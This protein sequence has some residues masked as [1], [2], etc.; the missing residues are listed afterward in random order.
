MKH[1]NKGQSIGSLKIYNLE[2]D[3]K[4]QN[5]TPSEQLPVSEQCIS[6][7][8]PSE[9]LTVSGQCISYITPLEQL[10]VS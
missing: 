4:V 8:T 7:I 9:Q 5:I 3:K 10:T 2:S 6:Y 1:M